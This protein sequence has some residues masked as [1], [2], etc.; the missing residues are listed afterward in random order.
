LKIA[1][2]FK[3]G[4]SRRRESARI[5]NFLRF[6]DAVGYRTDADGGVSRMIPQIVLAPKIGPRRILLA[7]LAFAGLATPAR[8]DPST[9]NVGYSIAFWDIPF[10]HTNYDGTW[11]ANSYSARA[12]FETGGVI[13]VF[14]KSVIDASVHG[15][16]GAQTISPALYDSYSRNRN[17]PLQ[18][19]RLTFDNDDPSTFADPPYSLTSNPVTE[20]QKKGALDPMSAITSILAGR[21]ATPTNPCGNAVRVFDGRR[22]YDITFTYLKDEAVKLNNGLFS[23]NAHLCQIHYRQIAGYDQK[24]VRQGRP[25]PDTFM[26]VV[27]LPAANAPGGQ[28]IVPLKFWSS[29]SLGTMTVTLNAIK[30]DGTDPPGMGAGG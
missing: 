28:Y 17:R 16:I 22:R 12:H 26:D 6:R 25:F 29:L 24:L 21:S 2:E 13:G 5:F 8:C 1:L 18:Q 30:V 9:L 23:G 7:V 20:E 10:G 3:A 14:W 11:G 27:N 15:D 19:V 4:R